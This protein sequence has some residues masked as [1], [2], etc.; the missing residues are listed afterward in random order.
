[1]T[2]IGINRGKSRDLDRYQSGS[3]RVVFD[4]RNRYFDPTY[5]ASPYYGQIVPRRDIRIYADNVLIFV[6]TVDDW[7]LD[8]APN[9]ESTASVSASDAFAFFAQ[10]SMVTTTSTARK[11]GSA[12]GN[13]L[14]SPG[15][16]WG[17]TPDVASIDTGIETI[18]ARS[19]TPNDNALAQMQLIETT[20]HGELFLSR[21]GKVKFYDRQHAYP[22][23]GVALLADDGTG[24]KY[25][26]VRVSYGSELLYTQTELQREGSSTIVQANDL[27]AQATYGIRTLSLSDT[28]FDSDDA[29]ANMATYLVGI[30]AEPEY[31]FEAVELDLANID[32]GALFLLYAELGNVVQVKFTPNGVGSAINKFCRI[33]SL[34]HQADNFTHK[35]TIGLGTL[36]TTLFQL[37]DAVF[38]ILDTGTLAF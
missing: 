35:L 13:I 6:G 26:S 5:T 36:D 20:E 4:N 29:M 24:F 25:S 16:A 23:Y 15:V 30:Y 31:R 10:Q 11:S 3:A 34:N 32:A 18:Q 38:G 28:L 21:D 37:D 22:S 1:V 17:T 2:N 8:Y 19:Y 27:T 9:G 7:N 33:I 14:Q 12:I